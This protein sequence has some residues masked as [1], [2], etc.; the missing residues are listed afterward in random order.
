MPKPDTSKTTPA[1]P[2]IEPSTAKRK[3]FKSDSLSSGAGAAAFV[4]VAMLVVS[5]LAYAGSQVWLQA[6]DDPNRAAAF[7]FFS[8]VLLGFLLLSSLRYSTQIALSFLDIWRGS[9]AENEPPPADYQWPFVSIIVPVYNEGVSIKASL[10]ALVKLDY[11]NYEIIVV[12]D[13]SS[14]QTYRRALDVS[15]LTKPL[16]RV[17]TQSNGGKADALNHGVS[18]AAGEIVVCV[19][20]DSLVH[21]DAL[22]H[23]VLHFRDPRVGAVSGCVRVLNRSKLIARL[24]ALEYIAG[25]ALPKRAQNLGGVV[26]VVPGPLGVFRKSAVAQVGGYDLDTFAED[27]D[28]SLKILAAG[29]HVSYESRALVS[30]EVPESINDLVKQRYRWTRGWVQVIKKRRWALSS[31]RI[32]PLQFTA[33]WFLVMDTFLWPALNVIGHITFIAGGLVSGV[34]EFITLWWFQLIAFDCATAAYCVIAE[35]ERHSLLWSAPFVRIF[36]S[37]FLDVTKLLSAVDEFTGVKM[38]WDKL[39]RLGSTS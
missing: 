16:I 37:L 20:G 25:N 8:A 15:R 27:F 14:D 29:W 26:T 6:F 11:P 39:Q 24:Q 9:P 31:P 38:G 33:M 34:H 35:R 3:S 18:A 22:K 13:G 19:D 12:D 5:V 4:A 21:S 2:S 7:T 17:L 30:T 28:I 32:G 23:A 36:Y 1:K 10:N